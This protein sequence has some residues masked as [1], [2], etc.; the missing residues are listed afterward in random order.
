MEIVISVE[1][2]R[3]AITGKT[4][5]RKCPCCDKY[6]KEYW[7]ENG[8]SPLPFPHPSWGE[9]YESGNCQ[10]CDGVAYVENA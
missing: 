4:T 1:T 2:F 6:G 5:Y 8:C 3:N 7:D 9:N 10:E